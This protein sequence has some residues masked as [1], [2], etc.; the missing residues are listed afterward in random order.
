MPEATGNNK[1]PRIVRMYSLIWTEFFSMPQT[2]RDNQR[3]A[4]KVIS[5]IMEV[6]AKVI[7]E[8]CR[9][10]Y[11]I[12]SSGSPRFKSSTQQ[13]SLKSVCRISSSE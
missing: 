6:N 9:A 8:L 5:P 12:F 13:V 2:F 10:L 11:K 7:L 1:N 3:N 4:A